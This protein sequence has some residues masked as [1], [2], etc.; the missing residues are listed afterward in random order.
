[1]EDG[2]PVTIIFLKYGKKYAIKC[3]T[4]VDFFGINRAIL[5][6]QWCKVSSDYYNCNLTDTSGG[7]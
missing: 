5:N 4:I 1:M 6:L 2:V 7:Q 3:Y